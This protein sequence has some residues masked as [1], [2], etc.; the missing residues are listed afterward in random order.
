[1]AHQSIPGHGKRFPGQLGIV[2]LVLTFVVA[3]VC[4][5]HASER[6]NVVSAFLI[7]QNSRRVLFEQNADAQIPPASLTKVISMYVALDHIRAGKASL[8]DKVKISARAARTGGS[9]M[10]L[11]RGETVSL[12][13]LLM[14]MA[15]SSGNDASVAVA[16][17][18]AGSTDR[19]VQLMNAKARALGMTE[20][21]FRNVNGLPAAGQKTTA[22]D[23]GK[24]AVSYLT[25]HPQ[26]LR[27]HSTRFIRHNKVITTNKNPMLGNC[28]GADGLKTGWVCASGYNLIS[29]VKRGNTRLVAVVLGAENSQVRGQEMNRL[30]DAGYRSLRGEGPSVA[31]VLPRLSPA[32][33]RIDL[34]KTNSLAYAEVSKH[35]KKIAARKGKLRAGKTGSKQHASAQVSKSSKSSKAVKGK[36]PDKSA[37]TSKAVATVRREKAKA[38][39]SNKSVRATKVQQARKAA[40]ARKTETKTT[41]K[42]SKPA[43]AASTKK[44]AAPSRTPVQ[45]A[46]RTDKRG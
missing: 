35:K 16:E 22:R 15:V 28:E 31:A 13:E 24:L 10:F 23:M 41:V 2:L 44:T 45:R 8:A 36:S 34:H 3:S 39:P 12:D 37:A 27:Y 33:Y 32:D 29:T 5:A 7:D 6:L 11:T 46:E 26:A 14:G 21:T 42:R 20:T 4:G 17:H 18:I 30:I 25:A 9:R 1:M 40:V 43:T 38:V 19:F